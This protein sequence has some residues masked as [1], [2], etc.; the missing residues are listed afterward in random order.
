MKDYFEER[1]MNITNY[2]IE[3]IATVRWTAKK[4]GIGRHQKN[5]KDIFYILMKRGEPEVGD[6]V[7]EE[8]YKGGERE[9]ADGYCAGDEGV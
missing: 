7:C 1:V 6:T 8:N 2:I 5:M 9:D 3:N 4:L